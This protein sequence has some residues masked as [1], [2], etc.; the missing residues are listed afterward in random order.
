MVMPGS[1]RWC[2]G[3]GYLNVEPNSSLSYA[4]TDCDGTG[5]EQPEEEECKVCGEMVVVGEDCDCCAYCGGTGRKYKNISPPD[6]FM[7]LVDDGPC[8]ACVESGR[9]ENK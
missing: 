2:Q 4:C 8:P 1:C 6:R 9:V 7:K 5:M 3:R